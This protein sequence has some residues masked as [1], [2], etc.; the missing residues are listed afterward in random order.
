MDNQQG[1]TVQHMELCLMFCASLDG[2]GVWGRMDTGLCVAE[3]LLHSPE[4]VTTL[5]I[6]YTPVQNKKFKEV[7]VKSI[8][9]NVSFK[10]YVFL[11]IFFLNDLFNDVSGTLKS[12]IIAVLLSVSLF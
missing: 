10:D 3:S 9:C 4:T 1:P 12:P 5:L 11:L 8:W 6:G 7:S 2:R